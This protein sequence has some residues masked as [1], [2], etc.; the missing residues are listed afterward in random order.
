MMGFLWL[1][2]GAAGLGAGRWEMFGLRWQAMIQ[3]L[4]FSSHQIGST[5]R[6]RLGGLLFDL[7]GQLHAGGSRSESASASSPAPSSCWPPCRGGRVR[8]SPAPDAPAPWPVGLTRQPHGRRR[9]CCLGSREAASGPP[10]HAR[11][12]AWHGERHRN[13]RRHRRHVHRRRVPLRRRRGRASPRCRRR[14][15]IPVAAVLAALDMAR[16]E[17]GIAAGGDRPLHPRHD[18]RDQCGAG[19]QGRAASA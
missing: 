14:A 13:R 7:F 18:G 8:A 5:R 11:R 10:Q 2:V 9:R 16:D 1:G 15:A 3:G 12:H 19:A 6:V 17:W 4:S